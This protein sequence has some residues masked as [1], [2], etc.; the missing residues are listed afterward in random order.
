MCGGKCED[1]AEHGFVC[2]NTWNCRDNKI[3]T[4]GK[5]NW[6]IMIGK[7][8]WR[9]CSCMTSMIF[10]VLVKVGKNKKVV[11]KERLT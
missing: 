2:A 1:Y 4:D 10:F 7:L 6:W 5:V 9:D 11:N 3:I 8:C